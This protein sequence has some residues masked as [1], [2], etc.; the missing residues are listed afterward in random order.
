MEN[1]VQSLKM[2]ASVIIFIVAITI[3]FTMFSKAKAT[4]DSIIKT[5]DR[6]AYLDSPEVNGGILYTSSEDIKTGSIATMTTDGNRIVKAQDVISVLYRYWLEHYNVTIIKGNE[7]I[8][9]FDSDTEARIQNL[10]NSG[11]II[12]DETGEQLRDEAGELQTVDKVLDKYAANISNN[13]KSEFTING[14]HLKNL[15]EIDSN[16]N[17]KFGAPW[18]GGDAEIIKRVNAELDGKNYIGKGGEV[19]LIK[20]RY[21]SYDSLRKLLE[22]YSKPDKKIVEYFYRTDNSKYL[23]D[24]DNKTNLLLENQLP[25]LEIVYVLE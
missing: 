18:L 23:E 25:T 5:Q 13:L 19:A 10:P 8:S 3:S 9:R 1:A 2:G 17:K 7:I 24:N 14:Q 15:Y 21:N 4:T 11:P 20:K 12:D 22:E 16:T 6:Q